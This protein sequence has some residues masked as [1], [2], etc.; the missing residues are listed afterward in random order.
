MNVGEAMMPTKKAA[1]LFGPS[2]KNYY[3]TFGNDGRH[4]FVLQPLGPRQCRW[5]FQCLCP[6]H[7]KAWFFTATHHHTL[8][9]AYKSW[10]LADARRNKNYQELTES[11]W[12]CRLLAGGAK[13]RGPA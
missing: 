5:R 1:R 3:F 13:G 6:G 8:H 4:V 11:E 12:L 7:D 9:P 10:G 2:P